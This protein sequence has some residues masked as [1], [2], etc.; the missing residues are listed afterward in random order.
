MKVERCRGPLRGMAA[1]ALVGAFALVFG[2]LFAAP[3]GAAGLNG[4]AAYSEGPQV[5]GKCHAQAYDDWLAH[6]HSRKLGI[7]GPALDALDGR[8]G[9]SGNARA[10]GFRLPEHDQDLFKWSNILFIVGASKHWKTRFVGLDGYV[11]TKNGANQ[12]NWED[13]SFT[14]YHK[15]EKKPYSCGTCHT[16]GYRKDGKVF[17]EQGFPGATTTGSPGIVGD[18]AHFNITCE[19]CHGPAAEH[20]KKPVKTNIVVDKTAKLCGTCHIRG[21]DANVVI[22][23]GGFIRHHEQYPEHLNSPHKAF[24][25][26]TCHKP[27]VTRAQ[28][29]KVAKGKQEVCD[30]CHAKQKTAYKGSAMQKAGVACQD[31]HMARATKSAIKTG[32]YDGDVWTHIMRI[33]PAADYSMFTA[34]GKAAKNAISLE[35]ACMRC[36]AGASKAEYAKIANFHTIGK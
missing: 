30:T 7:G 19:A 2:G 9:L 10:G 21:K 22:A 17:A 20:V 31:C 4:D 35:F 8:F 12:Y 23:K 34:D 6:G 29:I 33:N 14:N 36:H 11:I 5:C 27:H 16:T 25:C 13:G 26:G 1:G 28:G 15:D 18:W 3:A 32:P 24:S